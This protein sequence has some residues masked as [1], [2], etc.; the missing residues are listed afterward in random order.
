MLPEDTKRRRQAL[1]QQQLRQSAVDDHFQPVAPED[2][3]V[4]YSDEIFK[5]AAI[6]WLIETDQVGHNP[7]PFRSY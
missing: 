5:E 6:E 2:K 3:P 4:S 7:L 1:L